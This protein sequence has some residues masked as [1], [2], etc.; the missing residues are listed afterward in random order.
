MGFCFTHCVS[1]EE[2]KSNAPNDVHMSGNP[3]ILHLRNVA[4]LTQ[5]QAGRDPEQQLT[6]TNLVKTNHQHPSH[7][8]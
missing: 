5:Q 8:Q 1:L 2:Q 3:S 4:I 7:K 6:L